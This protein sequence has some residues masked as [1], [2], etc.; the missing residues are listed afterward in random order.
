[1]DVARPLLFFAFGCAAAL[2]LSGCGNTS[3][4]SNSDGVNKPSSTCAASAI[5]DRFLVQWSDGSITAEGAKDRETFNKEVFKP[6]RKE[7]LFAEHD[8]RVR[9]HA[10]NE[11]SVSASGAPTDDWGQQDVGAPDS[12]PITKGAGI[13]V[14]VVD[15]GVDIK[16]P[17]L[18]NQL[19]INTGEIPGN[20]IDDDHNGLIDDYYGYDFYGQ[21]GNIGDGSEGHGTH[22]SGIILA[23]HPTSGSGVK[24]LAPE[25]KLVPLGFMDDS[26]S[27]DIS[28]AMKAIDYAVARGAKIINASWGGE[29]CSKLLQT[30]VASLEAKGVLFVA[31]AG[32]GDQYGRGFNL[33]VRQEYPAA[34]GLS[35]QITVGAVNSYG[36]MTGFSNY[37]N[38]LVQLMA[39]GWK[40]KS[41]FPTALP[42]CPDHSVNTGICSMDGT[43]M[44]TPFVSGAAA[45]VWSYRPKATVS[46]VKKALLAGVTA[47][48]YLVA[49]KGRLNVRH[50]LDEIAKLVNP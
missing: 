8:Y 46:Q 34:Y 22:V 21:S 37:S 18:R 16:H 32:N 4:G 45:L 43:S 30:Q 12:W 11:G 39:P 17:Q 9:L 3:S 35:G 1:M 24:G 13:T 31:A 49:S 47:G 28:L 40:I 19:S 20:G 7:I 33:D 25:S 42:T 26:G 48:D 10:Q 50:A 36:V 44:A 41:T 14:A 23:E 29:F 6:N 27:G 5:P 38:N 15:S 2:A